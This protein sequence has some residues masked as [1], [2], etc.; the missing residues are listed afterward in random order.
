M[1]VRTEGISC[2]ERLGQSKARVRPVSGTVKK[3]VLNSHCVCACL[4]RL[5][6]HRVQ[7]EVGRL[8]VDAERIYLIASSQVVT[9]SAPSLGQVDC[10]VPCGGTLVVTS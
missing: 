9:S 2:F 1:L 8:V 3:G 7:R 4:L 6:I 5:R 10:G